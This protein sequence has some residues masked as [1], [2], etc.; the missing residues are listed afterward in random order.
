M[1]PPR[2]SLN[3]HSRILLLL[4]ALIVAVQL[5]TTVALLTYTDRM[6]R[7]LA[8]QQLQTG[9]RVFDQ[10]VDGRERLFRASMETVAADPLFRDALGAKPRAATPAALGLAG[11]RV[12]ADLVMLLGH[13]G[14]MVAGSVPAEAA[15]SGESP[16]MAK[17][18]ENFLQMVTVPIGAPESTGWLRMGFALR[19][20]DLKPVKDALTEES[21]SALIRKLRGP[22]LWM[23]GMVTVTAFIAALLCARMLSKPVRALASAARSLQLSKRR[24]S[25]AADGDDELANLSVAFHALAQRANYDALTGLPNR[26]LISARLTAAMERARRG[27][28]RLSVVFLDLNGFKKI[29]DELGHEMGDLVLRKT[30]QRLLRS[31]RPADTVA[32]LGGDEFVLLLEGV[33]QAEALRFM[34][35]LIPVIATAMES[36]GGP[37]RVGTSAGVAVYPDHAQDRESLLR[38]ADAAMYQSKARKLGPVAAR[39]LKEEPS[40][41]GPV[42]D[43]IDGTP[44]A[45]QPGPAPADP[46]DNEEWDHKDLATHR[47]RK[48]PAAPG[49]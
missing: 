18:K 1:A 5:T 22:Y 11:A 20:T 27:G 19:D 10:V 16:P 4:V 21:T 23:T 6:A 17:F 42:C 26:A 33:G 36:P 8:A 45:S 37:I 48:L 47:T 12:S 14:K 31:M 24:E 30:A 38:L 25:G 7:D 9:R 46:W 49:R 13:D 43:G 15:A 41:A 40:R 29:N 2:I 28:S 3:F 44:H 35:E 34:E 32:R 39:P